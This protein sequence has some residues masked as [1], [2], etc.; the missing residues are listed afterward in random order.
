M[1]KLKIFFIALALL[2][3]A[4]SIATLKAV[5]ISDTLY[6]GRS[7]WIIRT[8]VATYYCDKSSG[9]FSRMI[10]KKGN[11]WTALKREPWDKTPESA[12]ASYRGIPN[13]V[14]ME[15]DGGCGHHGANQAVSI[16]E[17]PNSILT[18]SKSGK[19][20]WHWTFYEDYACWE[21]LKSDT[22]RN[23]WLL[24]EGPV[25]GSY[26]PEISYWGN[27]EGE[28]LYNIPNTMGGEHIYGNWQWVYFGR[29]D[30]KPTLF[31]AQQTNDNSEDYFSYMSNSHE[32]IRATDG[33]VVFG[34]GRAVGS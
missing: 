11:D 32:G 14:F 3:M 18:T 21:I 4:G 6:E 19:W 20:K 16:Q 8:Q 34:F 5:C 9:G 31:I 24:Y 12:A 26:R 2:Y 23:Y 25:G 17:S 1:N 30:Q 33:M 27:N 7:N 28:H 29:S 22:A 10:D 13:A 15:E